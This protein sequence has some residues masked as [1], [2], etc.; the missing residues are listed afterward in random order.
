MCVV[1]VR[2][3]DNG[4]GCEKCWGLEQRPYPTGKGRLKRVGFQI[5]W[6]P[7]FF[8][9]FV[10]RSSLMSCQLKSRGDIFLHKN[11]VLKREIFYRTTF[12]KIVIGRVCALAQIFFRFR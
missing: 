8:T 2:I 10:M 5:C 3:A 9:P 12:A 11:Q 1:F 6:E 7:A 4:W